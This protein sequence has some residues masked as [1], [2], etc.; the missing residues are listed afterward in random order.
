ME[1]IIIKIVVYKTEL[2]QADLSK[3]II[4]VLIRNIFIQNTFCERLC[5]CH[6]MI[7]FTTRPFSGQWP[8]NIIWK[9][10]PKA[11]TAYPMKHTKDIQ[12]VINHRTLC[13]HEH[14]LVNHF[15]LSN[16]KSRTLPLS[17]HLSPPLSPQPLVQFHLG[18]IVRWISAN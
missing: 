15:K 2:L 9:P 12:F 11:C 10:R 16:P 5:W 7:T 3:Y 4:C 17:S 14:M 13:V 8:F 6:R 1:G 18:Q